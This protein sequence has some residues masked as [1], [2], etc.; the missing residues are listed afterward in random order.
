MNREYL[1]S[2]QERAQRLLE[3]SSDEEQS[4]QENFM[5]TK[6]KSRRVDLNEVLSNTD[7]NQ[8]NT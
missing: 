7:I 1:K 5:A 3:L 4:D 6:T 2:L 8:L